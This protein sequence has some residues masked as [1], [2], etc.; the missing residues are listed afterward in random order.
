MRGSYGLTNQ[1]FSDVNAFDNLFIRCINH[2]SELAICNGYSRLL[3]SRISK[4]MSTCL[5]FGYYPIAIASSSSL[6][7]FHYVLILQ[8]IHS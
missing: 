1:A 6:L 8:I 5:T 2:Q 4:L 7:F 3:R